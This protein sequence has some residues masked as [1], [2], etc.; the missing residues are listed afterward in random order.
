MQY[1]NLWQRELARERE[2]TLAAETEDGDELLNVKQA[3]TFLSISTPG[4]RRL[5]SRRLVPFIEIGGS[6][7]FLKRDLRAFL[8]SQRYEAHPMLNGRERKH[9]SFHL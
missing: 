6:I 5:K 3:A 4:V 2:N 8:D 1:Q 7:R 9:R